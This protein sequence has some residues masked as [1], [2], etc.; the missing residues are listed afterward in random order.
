MKN[1]L[2]QWRHNESDGVSN[3]HSPVCLLDRLFRRRSKKTSKLR[4]TGL[5][6]G[7]SPV[8]GEFPAQRA[9]NVENVS[10]WWRH[11]TYPKLTH[12]CGRCHTSQLVP[13]RSR[14]MGHGRMVSTLVSAVAGEGCLWNSGLL[15]PTT[16]RNWP[17]INVCP[18]TSARRFP[19]YK[20]KYH[21]YMNITKT[22][23]LQ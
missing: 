7:N 20:N 14:R 3:H 9:S 15:A 2:L 11:H 1:R 17:M 4:A 13:I 10:I 18:A 8:T 12:C 22:N 19:P 21:Q 6:A 5:C 16:R 23:T